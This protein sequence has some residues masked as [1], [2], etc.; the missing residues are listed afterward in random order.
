MR[1]ALD[2]FDYTPSGNLI[3]KASNALRAGLAAA[4]RCGGYWAAESLVCEMLRAAGLDIIPPENVG[5]LTEAPIVAEADYPDTG[6][7]P[8][9]AGGAAIWWF[10]DYQV[11]D[12]WEQLK[13]R[14][15]VVLT[16]APT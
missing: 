1:G 13:N 16:L 4:Y 11:M 15:R 8:V 9:P 12:P 6:P 5:A 7:S 10:P 14:G 3:I 2:G